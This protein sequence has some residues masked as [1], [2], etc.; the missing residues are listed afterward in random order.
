MFRPRYKLP[1]PNLPRMSS[2][3]PSSPELRALS[4][5]ALKIAPCRRHSQQV[6]L[7]YCQLS[8]VSR[9]PLF[10][11]SPSATPAACVSALGL[12]RRALLQSAAN[13]HP[14]PKLWSRLLRPTTA[15]SFRIRTSAKC[16][17]NSFRI[18][19]YKTLDL[20][21]FRIRTYRKKGEGGGSPRPYTG[22]QSN[23]PRGSSQDRG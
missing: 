8:A 14:Q 12:P 4:V 1:H 23:V 20:K 19:T 5:S 21:S 22:S 16:T 9:Q 10:S 15:N 17:C 6:G 18:R 11:F 13:V 3:I 2:R 7:S